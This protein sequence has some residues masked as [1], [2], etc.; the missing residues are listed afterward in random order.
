MGDRFFAYFMILLSIAA[1]SFL[2][3][4][5]TL[6]IFNLKHHIVYLKVDENLFR[7]VVYHL[8]YYSALML[9]M[10]LRRLFLV[11]VILRL[12]VLVLFLLRAWLLLSQFVDGAL[13]I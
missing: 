4:F 2:L 1:M 9:C 10:S 8:F 5:M 11:G 12:V 7:I 6:F 3:N 13:G